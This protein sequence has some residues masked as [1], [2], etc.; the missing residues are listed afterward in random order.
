[1]IMIDRTYLQLQV[2]IRWFKNRD[3]NENNTKIKHK[4][5]TS[6]TRCYGVVV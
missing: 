6:N 4:I 2:E 1:M 5:Y 3:K